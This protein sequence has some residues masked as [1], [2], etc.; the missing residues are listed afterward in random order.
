MLPLYPDDPIFKQIYEKTVDKSLQN[1]FL[2][3]TLKQS[4]VSAKIR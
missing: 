3:H 4:Y 1:E 2:H